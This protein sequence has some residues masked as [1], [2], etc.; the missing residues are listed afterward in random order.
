MPA[1]PAQ[2]VPEDPAWSIDGDPRLPL[3]QRLR[4][5]LDARIRQGQ[6][7]LGEALP[8][9]QALASL[10]GVSLGTVR[11]A[12]DLLVQDG[13]I[14]RRQGS[15]T[16]LRR[17]D[18]ANSLFRFFRLTGSG[19]RPILPESRVLHRTETPMT[20]DIAARLGLPAGSPALRLT[21]LRLDGDIPL[22]VDDIWLSAERFAPLATLPLSAL[23]PLLYPA[24][25]RYCQAAIC[26][27]VEELSVAT[28]DAA[29]AHLLRIDPGAPVVAIERLACGRAGEPLEWRRSLGRS[30]RFRYRVEIT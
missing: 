13:V 6:W 4:D 22:M 20:A 14:E 17:A 28:A 8:A 2:I 23:E 26:S 12:I 18:F 7:R 29:H 16:Y 15:G 5:D 9:E 19:G 3:Y 1:N 25:E 24:F 30:D 27:A 21:R 11:R 10:Y